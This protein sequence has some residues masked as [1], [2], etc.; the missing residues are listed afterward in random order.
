MN[1]QFSEIFKYEPQQENECLFP[2][3]LF[4]MIAEINTMPESARLW[5]Y[6][7]NRRF[8][9]EEKVQL[10]IA[11]ESF[12]NQWVAHGQN[13]R[14]SFSLE[15]DQF[16]VLM[17]D[18]SQAGA[19]GCSIDSSVT[20]IRKMESEFGI[21]FLDRSKIAFLRDEQV[22]LYGLNEIRGLVDSGQITSNMKTINNSVATYGD[23]QSN[24]IQ[25]VG[26]SWIKKYFN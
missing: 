15:Y 9:S 1:L 25:N 8:T 22:V 3:N 24:W 18:E 17:V 7:S 19:T 5:V 26:D 2:V 13:L 12:V 16:L 4:T 11:T 10:A 6:Q 14:V 20:F 23:W 21:S